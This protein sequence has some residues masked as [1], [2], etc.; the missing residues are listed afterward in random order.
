[1]KIKLLG[2]IFDL[3]STYAVIIICLSYLE[4]ICSNLVKTS[5]NDSKQILKNYNKWFSAYKKSKHSQR[6]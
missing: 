2:D 3:Y 5:K 6:A 1:M 4:E